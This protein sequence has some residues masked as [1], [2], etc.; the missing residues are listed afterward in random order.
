MLFR[1]G[2]EVIDVESGSEGVEIAS[3]GMADLVLSDINMAGMDGLEVLAKLRGQ[4]STS[5]IPFILMTGV[6]GQGDA[7]QGMELGADDYLAKPFRMETLLTAVRARFDRQ[8]AIETRAEANKNALLEIVSSTPDLVAIAEAGTYRL[9]YLNPSGR[10]ML[11]IGQNEDISSLTLADFHCGEKDHAR[12]H[13][14]IDWA[15]KYGTWV[16]ES[17]FVNRAGRRIPVA[18]HILA[19][20]GGGKEIVSLSVVARDIS[21]RLA[22]EHAIRESEKRYR[23]LIASQGRGGVPGAGQYARAGALHAVVFAVRFQNDHG[24]FHRRHRAALLDD[25]RAGPAAGGL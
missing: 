3:K 15:C 4:T 22:A 20:R 14:R 6:P 12:L 24:V 25:R 8:E 21:D 9:R 11:G 7:R 23:D 10:S 16:G 13:E 5:A 17:D 19:Q 1:H 2:Y 18:K